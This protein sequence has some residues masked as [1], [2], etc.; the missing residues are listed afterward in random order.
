M[1]LILKQKPARILPMLLTVHKIACLFL[2]SSAS[3]KMQQLAVNG[4]SKNS[5]RT[6]VM[7]RQAENQWP[8][9]KPDSAHQK[10]L[11]HGWA[12]CSS[13]Q[14][15]NLKFHQHCNRVVLLTMAV[16]CAN[17]HGIRIATHLRNKRLDPRTNK[18]LLCCLSHESANASGNATHYFD[19][20]IHREAY[21]AT[22]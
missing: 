7:M 9:C 16:Y 2:V 20:L 17:K 10:P 1:R 18:H 13:S 3:D 12:G 22:M 8:S 4:L 21:R 15:L 5:K 6:R 14:Q 19:H 11:A